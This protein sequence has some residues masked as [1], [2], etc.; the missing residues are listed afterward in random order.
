MKIKGNVKIVI[1]LFNVMV[2]Y[3]FF[4]YNLEEVDFFI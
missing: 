2:L 3:K 4:L 1:V